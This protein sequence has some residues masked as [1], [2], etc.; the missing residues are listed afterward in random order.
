MKCSSM[1]FEASAVFSA[2]VNPARTDYVNITVLC[3]NMADDM[4]YDIE[5]GVI[6]RVLF[7]LWVAFCSLCLI[8]CHLRRW[9]VNSCVGR[10]LINWRSAFRTRSQRHSV[11]W[12]YI[13]YSVFV[14]CSLVGHRIDNSKWANRSRQELRSRFVYHSFG[15]SFHC[16]PS[17]DIHIVAWAGR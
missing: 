2:V 6:H 9:Y 1:L 14:H 4:I 17:M 10:P 3:A 5:V 8:Y 7:G 16:R 15:C 12:D 11:D 13:Q